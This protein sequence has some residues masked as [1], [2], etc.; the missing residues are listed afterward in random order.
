MNLLSVLLNA[1]LT[2]NALA[3]L[4]KRTGLSVRQLRVLIPI[5]V[6]LLLRFLTNNASSQS[7]ASSL[8]GALT[9][10]TST[11]TLDQQFDQVDVEDGAKIIR[12]ILGDDTDRAIE[13]LA[14]ETQLSEQQVERGLDGLAPVLLSVLSAAVSQQ[15]AQTV[16]QP[17]VN[18]NDG[19]DLSEMLTLFAGAAAQPQQQTQ[20]SG[21]LL[22]LLLGGTAQPAQ[23]VQQSGGGLLEALLGMNSAPQQAQ[24]VQQSG[25]SMMGS[26]LGALLGAP[27]AQP[28][29]QV[30]QVQPIQQQS[31]NNV[32]GNTLVN[33]LLSALR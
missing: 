9:Q 19:L 3:A 15:Q 22:D 11:K 30:Q 28:A 27:T 31:V 32:N 23:P 26:L 29:Q 33:L 13:T 17:A 24:P 20:S 7:G 16:Q 2:D 8:L 21:G 5:A 18:L 6:P 25:G 1:M 14:A 4:S 10:H 12:H